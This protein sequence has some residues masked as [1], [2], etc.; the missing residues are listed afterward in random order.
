MFGEVDPLR[1]IEREIAT[2]RVA[3]CLAPS[4]RPLREESPAR[5]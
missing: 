3:V 1:R 2:L 5:A 4:R